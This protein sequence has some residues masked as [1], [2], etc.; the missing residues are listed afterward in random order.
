MNGLPSVLSCF[1]AEETSAT[2]AAAIVIECLR[3]SERLARL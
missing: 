3:L 2:H 1:L